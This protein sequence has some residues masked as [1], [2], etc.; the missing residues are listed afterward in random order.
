MTLHVH[1]LYKKTWPTSPEKALLLGK[2]SKENRN[3]Q[4]KDEVPRKEIEV[5]NNDKKKQLKLFF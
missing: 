3:E 1:L 2:I 4:Y 5:T